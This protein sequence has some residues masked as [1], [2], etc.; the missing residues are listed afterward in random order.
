MAADLI[1][2]MDQ[3]AKVIQ[4]MDIVARLP[5]QVMEYLMGLVGNS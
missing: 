2:P 5:T 3:M 4:E 1:R